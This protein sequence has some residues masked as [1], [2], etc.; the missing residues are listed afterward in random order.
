MTTL[1]IFFDISSPWTYMAFTRVEGVCAANGAQL[2][3]KPF[4]VAAVFREVNR[5]VAAR[6]AAPVQAKIEHVYK[7]M[8]DCARRCGIE[9][10]R[11]PVYGGGSQPLN[12]ARAMRGALLA[13]DAGLVVPYCS[14]VFH[15]YWQDLRDVSDPDVLIELAQ[16]AGLAPDDFLERADT[17]EIRARLA[18]NTDELIARGGFGTPTFFV[19]GDDM[20]FG[21]DRLEFVADAL[22]GARD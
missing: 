15:A 5:E 3:W 13:L 20:Y 19:A 17:A 1:E 11:P 9:I 4:Y 14:A 7:D 16:G 8:K 10:N 12:S 21:N 2:I 22:A 6:R 18:A